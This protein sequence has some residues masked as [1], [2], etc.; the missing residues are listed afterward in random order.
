[1]KTKKSGFNTSNADLSTN[2]L[3]IMDRP[4]MAVWNKMT[5][6][7]LVPLEV[8]KMIENITRVIKC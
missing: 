4:D 7:I 1:V 5:P 8:L 3:D 2:I 6:S